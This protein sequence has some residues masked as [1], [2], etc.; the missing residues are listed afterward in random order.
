VCLLLQH[1]EKQPE[2]RTC[3]LLFLFTYAFLLRMPSEAIH[4]TAGEGDNFLCRE[5]EL[6]VLTLKRR[7]NKREGS[8]LVR[9][10]WCSECPLTCPLHVLGPMLD[11]CNNG[12]RMFPLVTAASARKTLREMLAALEIPRARE[13]RTHDLRRGHAKDLQI[14]GL[15]FAGLCDSLCGR[16]CVSAG[17]PLWKILE[18]GEWKS[19]AFMDYLDMHK[20]ETDLVVQ[21]HVDES[22][23]EIEV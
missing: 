1:S 11:A 15:L 5:G 16:H 20:L 13:Y 2:Y 18:A 17:A 23:D 12:D 9:G 3:A 4:A 6:L 14:S 22:E 7:K 19:P 21:A 10:C 8:R